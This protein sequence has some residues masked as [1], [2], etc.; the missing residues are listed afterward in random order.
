MDLGVAVGHVVVVTVRI[1]KKVRRVRA[2]R[3]RGRAER[4][5]DVQAIQERLVPVEHAVAIGVFVN[6]DLVFAGKVTRRRERDL[7]IDSPPELRRG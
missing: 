4:S 6:R 1:K 3:H 2:R 5:H 7:V